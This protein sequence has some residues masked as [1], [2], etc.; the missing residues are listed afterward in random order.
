MKHVPYFAGVGLVGVVGLIAL[1]WEPR[2]PAE[3]A[4]A[5][6]V[7][8]TVSMRPETVQLFSAFSADIETRIPGQPNKPTASSDVKSPLQNPSKA[9]LPLKEPIKSTKVS[10]QKRPTVVNASGHIL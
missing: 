6:P 3:T 1:N 2:R 5:P 7:L 4:H 10:P 9:R 8:P